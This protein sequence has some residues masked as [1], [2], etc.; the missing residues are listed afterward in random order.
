[1]ITTSTEL[2]TSTSTTFA[3]EE[4][5]TTIENV[6]DEITT[7]EDLGI[8]EKI[9]NDVTDIADTFR[10]EYLLLGVGICNLVF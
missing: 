1:M 3:D 5:S 10:I 4:I 2:Q 7:T 6:D 8:I 9:H